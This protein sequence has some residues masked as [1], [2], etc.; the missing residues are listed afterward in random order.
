MLISVNFFFKLPVCNCNAWIQIKFACRWMDFLPFLLNCCI[1]LA[2]CFNS[3]HKFAKFHLLFHKRNE[4]INSIPPVGVY[5][6][7]GRQLAG[8]APRRYAN[9]KRYINPW[10]A[11]YFYLL[12]IIYSYSKYLQHPLLNIFL[13]S[14]FIKTV[15]YL[16]I[17]VL[18]FIQ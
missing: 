7:V 17:R 5:S 14:H 15:L 13:H 3:D 6:F 8:N 16:L 18:Y 1:S 11:L 10:D 12:C 9:H 2:C 4:K